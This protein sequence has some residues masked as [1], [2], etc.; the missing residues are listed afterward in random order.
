[1]KWVALIFAGLLGCVVVN[2]VRNAY[3]AQ[4]HSRLVGEVQTLRENRDQ[5]NSKWT[6]LL[7]EQKTLVNDNMTNQAVTAGLKLHLPNAQ[8]VVYLD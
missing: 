6:Q 4:Q 5:I 2:G 1:M 8:Q 7:L 3:Y